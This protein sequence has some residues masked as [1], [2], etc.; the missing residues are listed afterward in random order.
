[1]QTSRLDEATVRALAVEASVDPR[2][3]R[4]VARGESVRG[5][6]GARAR[7]ALESAGYPIVKRG[8]EPPRAA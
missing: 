3:I 6:A 1:M 7:K 5:M 8:T 2:T 4:R